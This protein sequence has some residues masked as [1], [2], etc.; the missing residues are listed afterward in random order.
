MTEQFIRERISQLRTNKGISEYK[1]SLDL[2]HSKS[3]IQSISSGKSLP[4]MPEFL[5]ICDYLGVSP[6]TFFDNTQ[7]D[8]ALVHELYLLSK[9]MDS[10]DLTALVAVAKRIVAK[11]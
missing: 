9:Q 8:P 6:M 4:S 3:Y 5:Y 10:E 11:R 7:S 2:G 1:M